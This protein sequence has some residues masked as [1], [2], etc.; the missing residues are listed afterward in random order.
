MKKRVYRESLRWNPD[1]V[2]IMLGSNDTKRRNWDPAVFR[3]DYRALVES[4]RELPSRPRVILIAPIRIFRIGGIPLMGLY[5]E[6]M[7]DGVRPAIRE[8]AEETGLE[9]V[10]LRDLFTDTH[11]MLDGVHPLRSG[12][13]KLAEAIYSG[14]KWQ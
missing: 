9:L 3:R 12:T 14:I 4:Y 13:E 10:D 1:I 5:P 2:L 7:E 11:Y 8:T 6:T